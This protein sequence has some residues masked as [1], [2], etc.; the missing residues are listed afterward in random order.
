MG[1][2]DISAEL[3]FSI[4]QNLSTIDLYRFMRTCHRVSSVLTPLY[5][6]HRLQYTD[7][8]AA[9]EW[10]ADHDDT[11]VAEIAISRGAKVD[12]K[13]EGQLY[14]YSPL[15]RAA[16]SDSPNVIRILVRHGAAVDGQGTDPLT[17]LYLAALF[18]RARAVSV[19]LELGAVIPLVYN[20]DR[21]G[22]PA[23]LS[24]SKGDVDCMKAFIAGGFDFNTKGAGRKTVLHEATNAPGGKMMQYLLEQ[25]G[26][27]AI[28]NTQDSQ[29]RTPLH[30]AVCCECSEEKVRLLL[31]YGANTGIEDC[32][33]FT[34]VGLARRR[35]MY[36]LD[37]VFL[38]FENN[39]PNQVWVRS[40]HTSAAVSRSERVP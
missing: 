30:Y 6:N 26:G 34:P 15:H 39:T 11:V 14:C 4:A 22:L 17:P 24:A 21:V 10:A 9:L 2:L 23:H 3:L 37:R 7:W 33:G 18:G 25:R 32:D 19:L 36:D 20:H 28:I 8:D 12:K 27:R 29:G 5:Y 40:A 35:G 1:I 16:L 31:R 38:E 13:I